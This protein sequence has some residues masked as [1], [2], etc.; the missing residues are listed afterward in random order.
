MATDVI[1]SVGIGGKLAISGVSVSPASV[2]NR[3]AVS[4]QAMDV[5]GFFGSLAFPTG[6]AN[7]GGVATDPSGAVVLTFV[8]VQVTIGAAAGQ[9]HRGESVTV[10]MQTSQAVPSSAAGQTLSVYIGLQQDFSGA[11]QGAPFTPGSNVIS[12]TVSV[13]YTAQSGSPGT[14]GPTPTPPAT[15]KAPS[16]TTILEVAGGVAGLLVVGAA[17][18]DYKLH[19]VSATHIEVVER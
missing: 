3:L 9:I 13:S 18:Y 11:I 1:Y 15:G 12:G 6:S 16:L 5:T 2:G 17:V 4:I 8:P 14:F 7:I 19:E 10:S